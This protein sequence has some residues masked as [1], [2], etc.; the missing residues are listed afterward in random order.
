MSL[1]RLR[2][3]LGEAGARRLAPGLPVWHL[4]A[5]WWPF[6]RRARRFAALQTEILEVAVALPGPTFLVCR[7]NPQEYEVHGPWTHAG[8][9]TWHV[10]ASCPVATLHQSLLIEGGWWIYCAPR[11]VDAATL[12]DAFRVE[13]ADLVEYA[14]SHAMPFLSQA[15]LDDDPWRVFVEPVE[16]QQRIA[17]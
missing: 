15:F 1:S 14:M 7:E 11:V 3:L 8:D 13:P 6:S 2:N 9:D 12:P 5:P 4:E 10:P 17:A 16:G